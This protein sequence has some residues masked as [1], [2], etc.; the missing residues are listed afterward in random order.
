MPPTLAAA[1]NLNVPIAKQQPIF[2]QYL[3]ANDPNRGGGSAWRLNMALSNILTPMINRRRKSQTLST[4]SMPTSNNR[5]RRVTTI[6]L[7]PRVN[8]KLIKSRSPSSDSLQIVCIGGGTATEPEK[9]EL[10]KTRRK[11]SLECTRKVSA[12]AKMNLPPVSEGTFSH[13]VYISF[14]GVGG[15]L[16]TEVVLK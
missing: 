11:L 7:S 13:S 14:R 10:E 4:Q 12:G 9:T 5:S 3:D 8:R 2:P 6:S 16:G 1:E 15:D